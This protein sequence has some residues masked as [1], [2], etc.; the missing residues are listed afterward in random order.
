MTAKLGSIGLLIL[1]IA[2]VIAGILGATSHA[3]PSQL[4]T[5][6]YILVGGAAGVTVAPTPTATTTVTT[7]PLTAGVPPIST[8]V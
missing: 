4:W 7:T 1:A 6:I 8:G 2:L 3:V 5:V